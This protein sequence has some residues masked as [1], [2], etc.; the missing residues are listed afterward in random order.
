[1]DSVAVTVIRSIYPHEWGV[2]HPTGLAYSANLGHL[3]LLDKER[4]TAVNSSLIVLTLYEE[5][6][7]RV[8]V[9]FPVDNALNI[10]FDDQ[11]RRLLLFNAQRAEIGQVMIDSDGKLDPTTLIRLSVA[12][13]QF[14][15]VQGIAVDNADNRLLLLDS[16]AQRIVSVDLDP[17]AALAKLSSLDLAQSGA[18]GLRGLAVHPTTHHLYIGNPAQRLLFEFTQSGDL[19]HRYPMN[20]VMNRARESVTPGNLQGF[21]FTPSADLTDPSDTIHLLLADS[22]FP[23]NYLADLYASDLA[24]RNRQGE[25]L[26]IALEDFPGLVSIAAEP[27]ILLDLVQTVNTSAFATNLLP[28]AANRLYLPIVVA[29]TTNGTV[30]TVNASAGLVPSPDPSGIAYI[31]TL[32]QL[33]ICDGEVDEMSGLFTGANLFETNLSGSL[34]AT[35]TTLGY[36]IEPTGIAFNPTN[37]HLFI[38]DDDKREIFEIVA[39]A[40]GL[41]NTSDDLVTSFDTA[42]FNSLDPEGVAYD[43][44]DNLLF[45]IDGINTEVYQ[46]NPGANGV[47]DGIPASGGDDVVT[48]FDVQIIGIFDPEGIHYDSTSGHLFL[49]GNNRNLIYEITTTGALV[50]RY[51]T[52][53]ANI[54]H[55]GDIT[56]A[57]SSNQPS[58][59]NFYVVDRG[60]DNDIDPSENDGRL[61][62]FT[63]AAENP[64]SR[65]I[66]AGLKPHQ[67]AGPGGADSEKSPQ[68]LRPSR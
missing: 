18:T 30:Q 25:I 54:L 63:L 5:L 19:I 49:V 46:V 26:E 29:T 4:S 10:T 43:S 28:V 57:P 7:N 32:N 55:N 1:M 36:S 41:Y 47:F 38:S 17:A 3:F 16:A 45:I 65:T 66:A 61:Y 21:V 51:N 13:L 22:Y 48:N 44:A 31:P 39:G 9:D 58:V 23:N 33:L 12:H 40:D 59:T 62:E 27:P 52:A 2:P 34:L 11:G 56:L 15:D 20:R 53:A 8:V 50:Q 37:Q 64:I 35:G 24:T 14:A 42:K 68:R 67:G 60:I 6:M